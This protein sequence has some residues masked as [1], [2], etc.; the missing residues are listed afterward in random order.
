MTSD[1]KAITFVLVALAFLAVVFAV[2]LMSLDAFTDDERNQLPR[3]DTATEVLVGAGD[4]TRGR[5]AE[6]TCA[7]IDWLR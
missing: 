1:A 2:S 4:F 5:H 6:Y 7:Q 3:C